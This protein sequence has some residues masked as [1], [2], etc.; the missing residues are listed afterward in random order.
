MRGV[1]CGVWEVK[2][3]T[4]MVCD[5]LGH[6]TLKILWNMKREPPFSM[7]THMLVI[8][9]EELVV[10]KPLTWKNLSNALFFLLL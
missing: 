7:D 5:F 1:G 3:V 9:K 2:S 6:K 8:L 4:A 10:S